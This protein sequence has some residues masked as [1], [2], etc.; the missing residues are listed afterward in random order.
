MERESGSLHW[1]DEAAQAVLAAGRAPVLSTGISPS[2][3]IHIGNLREVLT[4]Y[5]VEAVGRD[6]PKVRNI[7]SVPSRGS[8]I[9]VTRR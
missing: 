8:R 3:E 9:R 5:D 2:G 7:T 1:A 4:A 6:E